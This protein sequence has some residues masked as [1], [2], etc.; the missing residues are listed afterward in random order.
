MNYDID[1]DG[2][3]GPYGYSKQYVRSI[4]DKNKGK[5]LNVRISSFGGSL[6][7]ALDIAARLNEHGDV[8]VYLYAYCASAATVIALG[9]NRTIMDSNGFYLV[10]KVSNWV[11]IW[12]QLN[13]DQMQ[14]A[15]EELE[16]NKKDNDKMDLVLAKMYAK[17]CNKPVEQILDILKAGDW[18]TA[19]EAKD[20]G[21]VDEIGKGLSYGTPSVENKLNALGLPLPTATASAKRNIIDTFKS[22]INNSTTMLKDFL[23]LNGLLN[24]EGFDAEKDGVKLT[25]EQLTTI[26]NR[27]KADDE[28][29]DSLN[30][31]IA[32]K[33]AQ[34]AEL[35]EKVNE[36]QKQPAEDVARVTPEPE[37][38][39]ATSLFNRVKNLI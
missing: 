5:H 20:L 19:Q 2:Y 32:D 22:L 26:D 3:I 21:F 11:D 23:H 31:S 28:K 36:L 8:T 10:H 17:K 27:L 33:E 25:A 9:A 39:D 16:A 35:E 37:T 1:I 7:D 15:I 4:I 14:A 30:Q 13:A 18:L 6:D 38:V 29:I 34:I 24:V 12:G